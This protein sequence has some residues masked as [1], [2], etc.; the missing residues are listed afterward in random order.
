MI[1]WLFVELH[2]AYSITESAMKLPLETYVIN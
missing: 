1:L 2:I